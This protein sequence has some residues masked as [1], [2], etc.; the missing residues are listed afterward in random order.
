L[1]FITESIFPISSDTLTITT[2]VKTIFSTLIYSILACSLGSISL[3]FGFIK[4]STQ[5]SI[6]SA[7]II[8]CCICQMLAVSM[9]YLVITISFTVISIVVSYFLTA[10]L[11]HR[12]ANMQ[13]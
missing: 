7:V 6:V 13:V 1:F 9:Q 5:V 3:W 2:I 8:V 12:I 4:K 11:S 10:S